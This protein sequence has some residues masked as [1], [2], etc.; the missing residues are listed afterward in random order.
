MAPAGVRPP[1]I[2]CDTSSR[3]VAQSNSTLNTWLTGRRQPSWLN[4]AKS[5]A[6]TPR[7]PQAGQSPRTHSVQ[8]PAAVLPI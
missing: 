5:V 6:P 2:G 1:G 3:Q 7:N 4:N 8:L